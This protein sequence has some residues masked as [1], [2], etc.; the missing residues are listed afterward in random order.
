MVP[1]VRRGPLAPHQRVWTGR[2]GH[3][4]EVIGRERNV[5]FGQLKCRS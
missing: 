4:A 5:G 3:E 1:S 2:E